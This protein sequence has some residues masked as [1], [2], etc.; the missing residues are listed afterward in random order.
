MFL[1]V[2]LARHQLVAVIS[3]HLDAFKKNLGVRNTILKRLA[4]APAS[5][6]NYLESAGIWVQEHPILTT[7]IVVSV[8]AGTG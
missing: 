8:L 5:N 6:V 3:N 7:V 4:V 1:Y 2:A